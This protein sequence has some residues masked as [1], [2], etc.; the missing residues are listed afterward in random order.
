[1][2]CFRCERYCLRVEYSAGPLSVRPCVTARSHISEAALT[3]RDALSAMWTPSAISVPTLLRNA[4]ASFRVAKVLM[5]RLPLTL[6]SCTQASLTW[7]L[8]DFHLRL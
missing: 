6:Y 3:V 2:W 4:T 8:G 7:P 1:M 5:W